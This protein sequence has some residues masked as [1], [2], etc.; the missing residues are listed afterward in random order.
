MR[1]LVQMLESDGLSDCPLTCLVSMVRDRL[2][3]LTHSKFWMYRAPTQV[4]ADRA[5]M[6]SSI[7]AQLASAAMYCLR[8]STWPP[9]SN[10]LE[11]PLIISM[12]RRKGAR[13][14]QPVQTVQQ[15][16]RRDLLDPIS[17]MDG[18]QVAEVLLPNGRSMGGFIDPAF[19]GCQL[20]GHHFI[21]AGGRGSGCG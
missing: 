10:S 5:A 6:T 16:S 21:K 20:C 9:A 17:L 4:L 8:R 14:T 18:R 12:N 11:L 15:G 3:S 2:E 19:G 13:C 7:M 1:Q